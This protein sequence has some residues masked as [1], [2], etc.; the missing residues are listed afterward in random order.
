MTVAA[1]SSSECAASDRIAS[2]PVASPTAPLAIVSP[3]DAAIDVSA[4]RCLISCMA[5]SMN[6]ERNG[7]GRGRQVGPIR[8]LI[9]RIDGDDAKKLLNQYFDKCT[10]ATK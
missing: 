3:P 9:F 10:R 7:R 4:T 5:H 1:R 2:E 6:G 8:G